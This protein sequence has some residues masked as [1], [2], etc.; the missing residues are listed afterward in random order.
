MKIQAIYDSYKI[1]KNLQEHM[2]RVAAVGLSIAD[3]V[4]KKA[5]LD[6]D[7]VA[8]ALLLHDMGNI[9][10]YDLDK[11][12][13]SPEE[14]ERLRKVRDEFISKYGDEERAAM[15]AIAREVGAP[16]EAIHILENVGSSKVH[17][18]IESDDWYRKICSYADFRVAPYG[19]V[20]INERFDDV[21]KRYE[22]RVHALA[23]KEKTEGKRKNC[24]ILESQI[25]AVVSG[26]LSKI[27]DESV[28]PILSQLP[29]FEIGKRGYNTESMN[30][31]IKTVLTLILIVLAIA[32]IG[33]TGKPSLGPERPVAESR[34]ISLEDYF[35]LNISTLSPIKVTLGGKFYV[36]KVEAHGGAGTVY[37]EDGHS[38]YVADFTYSTDEQ[39]I[40]SVE[41]F[42][43][44]K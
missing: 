12:V 38:A 14:T 34:A 39:G 44:R 23:D 13:F 9:I 42:S 31:T 40:V 35:K 36:T 16:E 43:V 37:Y 6:R 15:F 33:F 17:L 1:P 28:A 32:L 22:S 3:M 4:S 18:T 19:I 24:L 41:T 26:D 10:K 8:T 27:T 29:E 21:L 5:M 30:K 25:Q 20:S 7:R 11:S 2:Y